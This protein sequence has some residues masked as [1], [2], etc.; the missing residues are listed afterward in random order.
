VELARSQGRAAIQR[1]GA[2]FPTSSDDK[3]HGVE[4]AGRQPTRTRAASLGRDERGASNGVVRRSEDGVSPGFGRPPCASRCKNNAYSA[5][6]GVGDRSFYGIVP[7]SPGVRIAF[8]DELHG[9]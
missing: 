7:L 9:G 6:N 3:S 5:Y 1:A 8:G 2:S 4:E